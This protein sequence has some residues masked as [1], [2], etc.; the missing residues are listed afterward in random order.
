MTNQF[1]LR[2]ATRQG[3]RPLVGL[4]AESSCGKTYS[5]LLLARGFAGAGRI[6]MIDSESGRGSLY[7]DVIPGGYEVLDLSEPFSPAR[8]MEAIRAVE[9]SGAAIGVIDSASHEWEGIGGVLDMAA[10]NEER[11]GKPGL[12]NWKTPKL[13]HSRLMLKLLQSPIPWIVCLRAKY[14][15]RQTKNERGKTEIIKDDMVSP[16]QAEDFIFELTVHGW[17]DANHTFHQTKISHPSLREVFPD[18]AP[19]TLSHGAALAAWCQQAASPAAPAPAPKEKAASSP[20]ADLK[21]KL[22]SIY[23]PP[24]RREKTPENL[25]ADLRTWKILDGERS[26]SALSAAELQIVLDRLEIQMQEV[27]P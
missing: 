4:Y 8:Y 11:S 24:G 6:A 10:K 15:S 26:L 14:K 23:V 27:I 13:E 2:P 19:I 20:L 12:H 25:E 5:A 9:Q 7:A 22:W 17:I 21:R 3:V 1:S 18:G 16:I